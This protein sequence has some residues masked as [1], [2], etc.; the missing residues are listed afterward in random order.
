VH[1]WGAVDCMLTPD[2]FFGRIH[3][4]VYRQRDGLLRRVAVARRG[5]GA[6]RYICPLTDS[7]VLLTEET[8][9][10]A[11]ARPRAR[12]RCPACGEMHL[13]ARDDKEPAPIV[14]APSGP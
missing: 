9:L 3:P 1:Q 10:K 4:A 11:L 7:I 5:H 12:L 13:L 8:Q 14:S 2:P 6:W